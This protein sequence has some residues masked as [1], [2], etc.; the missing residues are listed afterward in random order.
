MKKLL[1]KIL[2]FAIVTV[3]FTLTVF[4]TYAAELNSISD[5]LN[6]TAVY[7]NTL[8]VPTV[9]SFNGEWEIIGLARGGYLSDSIKEEYYI[10]V[11]DYVKS[12]GLS[13]LD[14]NKS[15]DNSR[16]IL[17]LT[18][19]GKDVT[20]VVGYNLLEPLCDF[21]YVTTQGINGAVWALLALDSK[22]YDAPMPIRTD[23]IEFILSLQIS[24]GG[25]GLTTKRFDIDITSMVLQSLS[26]YYTTNEMVSAAV[27][28]ALV[29]LSKSQNKNGGFSSWSVENCESCAQVITALTALGIDPETDERFIKDGNSVLDALMSF[30]VNNGFSHSYNSSYDQMATEQSFYA[31]VS[32]KRLIEN[33]TSLYDMRDV[34]Y[35]AMDINLDGMITVDDVTVLQKYLAGFINLNST[36]LEIAEINDDG[37]IT[38]DDVTYI[39]KFLSGML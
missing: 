12:I 19:I 9:G 13:K 5:K 32:Y 20:N 24:D 3:L 18:A 8:N 26:P 4:Q 17:A 7:F 23:L 15:T 30:S 14:N 28:K 38:V 10:N 33:K 25:W 21:D 34:N 35:L 27:D 37:M 6:A 11:Q 22:N 31:L 1:C 36:Q 29:K 16:V 2:S 39:Q